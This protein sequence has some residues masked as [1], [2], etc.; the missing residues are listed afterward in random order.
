MLLGAGGAAANGAAMPLFALIF[1]G[2]VN[3]FGGNEDD[4][5]ALTEQVTKYSR[6]RGGGRQ[7]ANRCAWVWVVSPLCVGVKVGG[8]AGRRLCV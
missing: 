4:P 8:R 5:D 1:G 7:L 2:L 3:S 6:E